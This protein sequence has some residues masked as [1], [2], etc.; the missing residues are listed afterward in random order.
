MNDIEAINVLEEKVE[1]LEERIKAFEKFGLERQI[2]F[3]SYCDIQSTLAE[4]AATKRAILG[5]RK[6]I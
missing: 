3:I 1:R 5:L 6:E 2:K 4:L